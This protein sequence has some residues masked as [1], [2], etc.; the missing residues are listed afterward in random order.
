MQI[1]SPTSAFDFKTIRLD[2][3]GRTLQKQTGKAQSFKEP[4]PNGSF[5]E[6]VMVPKTVGRVGSPVTEEGRMPDEEEPYQVTLGTFYISKYPITQ[7]QWKAVASLSQI[8]QSL[9]P[10]P[11]A[12]SGANRPV[13]Q[14]SWLEAVEFCARLSL[15][16]DKIYRLPTEVEWEYA[17]RYGVES[18]FCFG[19]SLTTDI[20]NCR[21]EEADRASND[22]CTTDVDRSPYANSIGLY[23]LHGNVW[24]WCLKSLADDEVEDL[25]YQQPARGGS[26]REKPLACRSALSFMFASETKESS[27]GFRIVHSELKHST[28]SDSSSTFTQEMLSHN[29]VG[30]DLIVYGDVI[31]FVNREKS[32]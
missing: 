9:N 29:K 12:F 31:Q 8:S 21:I 10:A 6:M 1:A 7:S 24:E 3:F 28:N 23:D 4:L 32:E 2:K 25:H 26:W 22:R 14:I 17:C 30:R 20:A 18:P 15:M 13:E 16:E 27:V 19:E 5:I 11:S